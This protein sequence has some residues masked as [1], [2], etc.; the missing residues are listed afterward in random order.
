L[1]EVRNMFVEDNNHMLNNIEIT[2]KSKQ[3]CKFRKRTLA[4]RAYFLSSVSTPDVNLDRHVNL[5]EE[6]DQL[7]SQ[8]HRLLDIYYPEHNVII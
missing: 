4:Q 7:Y 2:K 8:L 3:V 1:P 6:F 5:Q